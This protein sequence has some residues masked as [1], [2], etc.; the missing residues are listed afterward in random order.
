MGA[1]TTQMIKELRERTN[2]GMMDCKKALQ[3]C[4]GD[5]DKAVDWLRQKGLAVAAKRA[6]RATSEGTVQCY[7]HAGN[8]IGVLVEVDCETDFVAKNEQFVQ[9]AKDLALHIC[10]ANPVAMR[11]EDVPQELVER[12]KEIY[13]QQAIESGKP[14]NIVEKIIEGRLDKFFKEVC[15]L[16]QPY[17]K[18]PDITIQDKLNELIAKMGENITIKRYVRFQV[19][20]D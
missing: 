11:R 2:A 1:I 4:G 16:E 8:K 13:R 12:E 9:F 15:L 10:A 18:D 7:L 6:G 5:M 19:G 14:E 3:E 20:T 17:V